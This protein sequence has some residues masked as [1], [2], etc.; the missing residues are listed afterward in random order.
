L[1]KSLVLAVVMEAILLR[2]IPMT[3]MRGKMDISREGTIPLRLV[4]CTINGER[5]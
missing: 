2:I 3:R 4:K 1:E 5:V